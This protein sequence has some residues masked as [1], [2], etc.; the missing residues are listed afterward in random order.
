MKADRRPAGA[1]R[2]L[3]LVTL[4]AAFLRLANPTAVR[5]PLT[6]LVR[7]RRAGWERVYLPSAPTARPVGRRTGTCASPGTRTASAS[8]CTPTSS[9]S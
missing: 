7:E 3:L 1:C 4:I 5:E 2:L 6:F 8:G 9:C